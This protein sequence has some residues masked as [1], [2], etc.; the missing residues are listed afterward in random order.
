MKHNKA[1]WP[2]LLREGGWRRSLPKTFPATYTRM[3]KGK[4]QHVTWIEELGVY[5]LYANNI[6]LGS[7][8]HNRPSLTE[9][10]ALADSI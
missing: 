6:M 2:T 10:L 8:P 9:V 3:K 1:N 7:N 5:A 4:R